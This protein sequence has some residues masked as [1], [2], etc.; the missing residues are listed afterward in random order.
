MIAACDSHCIVDERL[1]YLGVLQVIFVEAR[2][3]VVELVRSCDRRWWLTCMLHSLSFRWWFNY[4]RQRL[5]QN[6]SF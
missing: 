2:N 6:W 4:C 3:S 1:L 5:L